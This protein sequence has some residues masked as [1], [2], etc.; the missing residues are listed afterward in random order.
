MCRRRKENSLHENCD[1]GR[2]CC[3]TCTAERPAGAAAS[4]EKCAGGYSGIRKRRDISGSGKESALYCRISGYLYGWHD[5][6]GGGKEAAENQH[7][8]PAGFYHDLDRPCA[9]GLSGTGAALSG[10]AL[11]RSGHRRADGRAACP[12][13]A[14]GQIYG[15]KGGGKRDPSALSGHRLRRTLRPL[16]LRPYDGSKDACHTPTLQDVHRPTKG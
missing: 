11:Y 12:H 7:G 10:Q 5:G 16:D 1:C 2:S 15:A 8:L 9:G 14:A 13:T 6:H 4:P 3:G